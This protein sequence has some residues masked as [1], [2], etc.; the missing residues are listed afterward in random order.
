MIELVG[1][2][3]LESFMKPEIKCTVWRA[4]LAGAAITGALGVAAYVAFPR[5]PPQKLLR[6]ARRALQ[7]QEF[8]R[9]EKF[10]A[11][12]PQAAPEFP[13]ALLIAGEAATR[14]H[15]YE[16]A[17][18]W[19]EKMPTW[20]NDQF[21]T[22]TYCVGDLLFQLGEARK[23]EDRYRRV[24]DMR[25]SDAWAREQLAS[26]LVT[27]G[28]RWEAIPELFELV[29]SQHES[30]D[31]LLLL[32]DPDSVMELV[33]SLPKF[34]ERAP[35]D[36][37]PLI[38]LAKFAI[39]SS[40]SAT[41]ER[42]ARQVADVAPGQ[43]EAWAIFGR[44]LLERPG[45]DSIISEW[46]QHVP[47]SAEAH[48]D[49][50]TVRGRW[51]EARGEPKAAIRCF[52]EAL[53]RF[54]D[55]RTANYHLG[56]ALLKLE[57]PQSELAAPFL[58]RAERLEKLKNVA[59]MIYRSRTSVRHIRQAAELTESLGR[60]WES[61]GWCR[62]A[63]REQPHLDWAR[64]AMRRVSVRLSDDF[65]RVAPASNFAGQI[66][67]S[68][69][70]LPSWIAVPGDR[71]A[72]D[73]PASTAREVSFE[74]SAAAGGI[75]FHYFNGTA[76]P[77][78]GKLIYQTLGGGVA[79]ID[80]DGDLLPD[81]YFSQGAAVP[82][83]ED[84]GEYQDCLYRNLGDGRFAEVTAAAD[85]GDRHHTLGVSAGDYDNDGFPDLYLANAGRNRLHHNNGDGT[86]T[87][88]TTSAGLAGEHC[89]ASCLIADL[90]GDAWPE[91]YDVNYL[92]E[93]DV[94][95]LTCQK[96]GRLRSCDPRLFEAE[97]DQLFLNLGDG[98]FEDISQAAGIRVAGGKG[99]G[100]IAADFS[101][102]GMPGLFVS[103]DSTSN[104]YFLN[105]TQRRG[106]PLRFRENS[107]AAGVA[108]NS[109]GKSQASMG[110]AVD[111]ADGDGLLD[112]VVTN[113]YEEAIAFYH[114][115]APNVFEEVN[116]RFGLREPSLFQL[117]FGT[118]FI[119]GDLDGNPDLIVTNGH[120]EDYSDQAKPYRMRP[121]Y[122]RN[123]GGRKFQELNADSLGPF[124]AGKYLG[125]GLARIDWNR[126]GREDIVIS[127]LDAPAALLTNTT[128]NAGHFLAL[129]IVGTESARDAIG[130]TV[131]WTAEERS[132][133]RQ[134]TAG[135][136]YMASN[137]RQLVF[138][139]GE[140]RKA[141][142]V[143]I[144]WP[145]GLE[146]RFTEVEADCHWL[147]IE[148]R[149]SLQRMPPHTSFTIV[150]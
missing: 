130:A 7:L 40:D 20:A 60:L 23:A 2:H 116:R 35:D 34:R 138:G 71:H 18:A 39:D 131:Q 127:H 8:A 147:A 142:T 113:F 73:K 148:G 76:P 66:D 13:D 31:Q 52:A 22:A 68:A 44:A 48:P 144:R 4:I 59:T 15:Q 28:R 38:A 30:V 149:Q 139:L 72:G 124:F 95:A 103:N 122:F 56:Q 74:N 106:G 67:L 51:A 136:G 45:D 6:Q 78:D 115:V 79:A 101:G 134:L 63:L 64:N 88:V 108:Y 32:A 145:S 111:D 114:Q 150:H 118:Q 19:Y 129:R 125:R 135:D 99:L 3:S 10:A 25:P 70:P 61:A 117:G 9:A 107:L 105:E 96:D 98:R 85:L 57:P 94:Y 21:V 42:F 14:Q 53:R 126:D 90:N 82:G 43:V 140:A 128:R 137:E 100:I 141:D 24:L 109:D 93:P 1:S 75:S 41:A 143:T 54:P 55:S 110:I 77:G 11:Q 132:R 46:N 83:G 119:D 112:V 89:T 26:L 81:I 33:P 37:L 91:L 92:A 146:Q 47:P 104:F 87:D 29:R 86:F 97:Q 27:F 84:D 36:P 80:Y 120:I 16:Q 102:Y 62:A 5:D 50:W 17:I 133:F 65:P 12:V 58:D 69:F 121:Q 49:V 123:L